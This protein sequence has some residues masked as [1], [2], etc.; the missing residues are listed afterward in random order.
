V[1]EES[2][3][4]LGLGLKANTSLLYLGLI[5][6][7]ITE[8]GHQAIVSA[9]FHEEHDEGVFYRDGWKEAAEWKQGHLMVRA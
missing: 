9:G 7:D 5:V 1:R 8:V 3:L 6:N 2:V 4:W